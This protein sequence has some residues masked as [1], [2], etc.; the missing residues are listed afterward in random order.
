MMTVQDTNLTS[1][2][3][4]YP[5]T[6]A[7][8]EGMD[9]AA[10]YH[11]DKD[12]L[13]GSNSSAVMA[14]DLLARVAAESQTAHSTFKFGTIAV[15][16]RSSMN[17]RTANGEDVS[18][19]LPLVA[20][21]GLL[22]NLIGYEE[23]V[24][25]VP[26]G[27]VAIIGGGRRL[28]CLEILTGQSSTSEEYAAQYFGTFP[29]D[30]AI[31]YLLVSEEEA[32]AIS[33][34]ENS[35]RKAMHGADYASA[36]FAL[37]NAGA[38]VD[39]LAVSFGIEAKVVRQYLKLANL[40]PKLFELYRKDELS[41]EQVRVYAITDDHAKQQSTLAAL[42][43]RASE[44]QIRK[45]LTEGNVPATDPLVKYVTLAAYQAAGGAV[46][47]DLFSSN[48][49]TYLTDVPLLH[50]LAT[51]KLAK[52][53][54]RV[55]KE[56]HAWVD[57]RATFTYADKADFAAVRNV[58]RTPTDEEANELAA[59]DTSLSELNGILATALEK[60]ESADE[61]SDEVSQIR[62][63]INDLNKREREIRRALYGAHV[64]DKALAGAIVTVDDYGHA[65]VVTG[66]IRSADQSKMEK[67]DQYG[68][69]QQPKVK[70]DHS[71][72]LTSILTSHRTAAAQAELMQRPTVALALLTAAL[73]R[74]VLLDQHARWASTTACKIT[75]TSPRLADEVT[76]SKA[77]EAIEEK[78]TA[79]TALLPEDTSGENLFIWMQQQPQ[80]V[81]LDLLAFCTSVSCDFTLMRETTGDNSF[82]AVAAAVELDMRN[83]WAPT[84]ETYFSHVSKTRA[85]AVVQAAT[86]IE[87]SVP[88]EKMKK[89]EAAEAAALAVVGTG[90]LPELLRAG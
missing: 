81:V 6:I 32:V 13:A 25:G 83:W 64:A 71:D 22:Q 7:S 23:R 24:N 28:K 21:K 57:V 34:A 30:Y 78:R 37:F 80:T 66:L 46:E 72:R 18:D 19:L 42:G 86:S 53:A 58:T 10:A 27:R 82:P 51:D 47:S 76:G 44:W 15:L 62:E 49:T 79:L 2:L 67:L 56:G 65:T 36:M 89:T 8:Q 9:A 60:E 31:P 55:Q 69:M 29:D 26:T 77:A 84:A 17:V 73:T 3:N 5:L 4:T 14:S 48:D 61:E 50:K 90:W 11:D 45:L 63:S 43:P 38:A 41:L 12:V 35:G 87:R 75:Q 88:L 68:S 85:M 33:L 70:P 39:E 20:S 52:K 54:A 16:F 74:E 1:N 40:A 59:I